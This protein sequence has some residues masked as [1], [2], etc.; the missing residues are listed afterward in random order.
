LADHL[1]RCLHIW[2]A[3]P[4]AA[5][6]ST[7]L[8][9]LVNTAMTKMFLHLLAEMKALDA[10]IIAASLTSVVIAT[11][12]HSLAT[13]AAYISFLTKT[14]ISRELF[15]WVLLE[16][17][18]AWCVLLWRDRFNFAGVAAAGGGAALAKAS[19]SQHCA[20]AT[21]GRGV[22]EIE[23]AKN[24]TTYQAEWSLR[25][26][27]PPAVHKYFDDIVQRVVTR[28]WLASHEATAPAAVRCCLFLLLTIPPLPIQPLHLP[29]CSVLA[30]WFAAIQAVHW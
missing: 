2:L 4:A 13:A 11:R 5:L 24:A 18:Q 25:N 7:Q 21:Q 15:N 14:L 29:S 9:A 17:V 10:V 27:L 19:G 16:P 28:P 22:S 23:E 8:L 3:S 26:F 12:K 1:I 6:H 30:S 20:T